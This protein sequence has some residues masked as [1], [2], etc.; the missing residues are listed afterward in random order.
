M[1]YGSFDDAQIEAVKS[2]EGVEQKPIEQT[3][4]PEPNHTAPQGNSFNP[5][6]ERMNTSHAETQRYVICPHCGEKIYLE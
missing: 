2:N 3:Y 5:P 4:Q 6:E 1:S